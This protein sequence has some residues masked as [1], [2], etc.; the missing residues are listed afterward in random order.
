MFIAPRPSGHLFDTSQLVGDAL[1]DQA[2]NDEKFKTDNK[3]TTLPN[4]KDSNPSK[5]ASWSKR[6][7]PIP[8]RL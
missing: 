8:T 4:A 6:L 7:S 1:A 2:Q 3:I 5:S